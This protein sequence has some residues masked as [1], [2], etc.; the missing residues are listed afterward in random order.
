MSKIY[1]LINCFKQFI[2]LSRIILCLEGRESRS[3]YVHIYIFC[4]VVSNRYYHSVWV[5]L[6]VMARKPYSIF[7]RS[8]E[9]EPHYQMQFSVLPRTPLI[10]WVQPL[11]RRYTQYIL[12][13]ADSAYIVKWV[14]LVYF[15]WVYGLFLSEKFFNRSRNPQRFKMLFIVSIGV[16]I[17]HGFS[18]IFTCTA[19]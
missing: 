11:Y 14:H 9:L 7:P 17:L 5:A 3:L 16:I 8:S 13:S 15:C 2:S 1:W 12:I 18:G 6:G 10:G 19:N 4:F